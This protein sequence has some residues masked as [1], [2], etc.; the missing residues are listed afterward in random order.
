MANP[1]PLV[2][3]SA[4]GRSMFTH[5]LVLTLLPGTLALVTFR[6]FLALTFVAEVSWLE[7]QTLNVP[8][9]HHSFPPKK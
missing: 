7:K 2:G 5:H 1:G 3:L 8:T 4:P 9:F 6:T